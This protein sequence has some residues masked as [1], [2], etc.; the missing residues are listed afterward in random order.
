MLDRGR[1][2]GDFVR[3]CTHDRAGRFQRADAATGGQR[4]GE[5]FATANRIKKGGRLSR[6]AAISSTT[7][8][9]AP[10]GVVARG[11]FYG[12]TRVAQAFEMNAFHNAGAVRVQAGND[13][14]SETHCAE[15]AGNALLQEPAHLRHHFFPDGI[16]PPKR[17]SVRATAEEFAARARRLHVVRAFSGRVIPGCRKGMGKQ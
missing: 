7:S 12:V 16:A 10:S 14:A 8:S 5:L 13:A 15:L 17:L 1:V 3:P 9:S 2:H 6:A 4:D 11:K